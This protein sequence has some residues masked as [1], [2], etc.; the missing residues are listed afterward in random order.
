MRLL[1]FAMIA[2]HACLNMA[3]AH[4]ETPCRI[5]LQAALPL[6]YASNLPLVEIK[7]NGVPTLLGVDTGAKTILTPE[8]VKSLGLTRDWRRTRAIGTTAILLSQNY[9]AGDLEF[10]GRHYQY[11]SLPAFALRQDSASVKGLLG[12]DILADFDLDFDFPN[13]KLSVYKVSGCKTLTPPGFTPSSSIRFSFNDQRGA[14]LD[15]ELDGK[16]LTALIDTGATNIY[17]MRAAASRLK[18]T[19]STVNTDL[20]VDATGIGNVT[21]KQLQHQFQSLKVGGETVREP[22]L[23]IVPTPVTSADILLGQRFLFSRR[24]FISNAT[25]TLFLEKPAAPVFSFA[26]SHV[27]RQPSTKTGGNSEENV[28]PPGPPV[29]SEAPAILG[30]GA[31]ENSAPNAEPAAPPALSYAPSHVIRQAGAKSGNDSEAASLPPGPPLD[32]SGK[33]DSAQNGEPPVPPAF[34]YT[35]SIAVRR[36]TGLN[37]P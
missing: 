30:E 24:F 14:V 31:K 8:A 27:V 19:A 17:I 28:L 2:A 25:R 36:P 4:S 5:N 26:P 10:A 37:A 11:K 6:G 13:K 29:I 33:K 3:P 7:I 32:G 15:A 23:G 1:I 18:V 22:L 20:S 12:T 35:P 21:V 34:S 16:K 9:I